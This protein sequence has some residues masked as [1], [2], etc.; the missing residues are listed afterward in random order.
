LKSLL[1]VKPSNATAEVTLWGSYLDGK[2]IPDPYY[3]GMGGFEN[4]FQQCIKLSNAFLDEVTSRKY[5]EDGR[6]FGP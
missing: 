5:I 3:G 2:S 6:N 1:R 4:V